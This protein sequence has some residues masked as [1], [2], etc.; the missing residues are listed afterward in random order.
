MSRV[1]TSLLIG[2]TGFIGRHLAEH[3]IKRNQRVI[4]TYHHKSKIAAFPK[5]ARLVYC[6]VSGRN[7]LKRILRKSRADYV[8]YLAAQSSVRHAWMKPLET[9]EV[10]FLGGVR[11]LEAIREL[12]QNPRVLIFSSGTTY[13]LSH[14]E[15]RKL[16]EEACLRPKDPY[17]V[18]KLALDYFGQLYARAHGMPVVV[19]RLANL[20]GPGQSVVFSLTNFVFQIAQAERNGR[21]TLDVGNLSSERDYLDVRDGVKAVYLAMQHGKPGEAYNIASG[22]SRKLGDVLSQMIRLSR[23]D[24]GAVKIKKKAAL[25]PV[26]EISSIRLDASKLRRL[27]GWR[28]KISFRQ[29]LLD[30]LEEWRRKS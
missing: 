28:P 21:T 11:L 10:N 16:D 19:V 8:Y 7:D 18:S 15:G 24:P 9:L 13:G 26:D 12:K 3:L 23:L 2:A 1:K 14:S 30:V 25:I 6:D 22:V 5:Q 27:T 29:T 17:S 4:G 20:V